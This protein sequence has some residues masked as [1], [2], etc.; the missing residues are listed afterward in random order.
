MSLAI[1]AD[2]RAIFFDAV[3]TLIHP[4]PPATAVYA[5]VG[6]RHGSRLDESEIAAGFRAAFQREEE[7]DRTVG[8]RTNEERE[9]ARWRCIVDSVLFDTRESDAC[10]QELWNH[11]SRP[12]AWRIEPDTAP[13][14]SALRERGYVLGVASNYDHRLRM[15]ATGL[16][17]FE[18]FTHLAVSAELQW[19][20]PAREFFAALCKLTGLDPTRILLVG[21]DRIND[22][23]GALAVGMHAILVDP[24]FRYP[25][26]IR[27]ERLSEL[28]EC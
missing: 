19:R 15:V 6:R 28:V 10:F 14:L 11:F 2:V 22:Y 18:H 1:S 24:A 20:K 25:E 8:G 26:T 23:E 27:I 16:P 4:H 12:S 9:V 7:F 17:E 5:E 13:V 21:D 3:G